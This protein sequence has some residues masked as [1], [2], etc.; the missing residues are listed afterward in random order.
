MAVISEDSPNVVRPVGPHCLYRLMT[1][2]LESVRGSRPLD[3]VR[4]CVQDSEASMA[5]IAFGNIAR[6]LADHTCFEL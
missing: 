6:A 5:I 1:S 3:E 2:V 4:L